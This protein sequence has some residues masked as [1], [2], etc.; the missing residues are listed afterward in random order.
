MSKRICKYQRSI[1][2][3][4]TGKIKTETLSFTEAQINSVGGV[5]ERNGV[6]IVLAQKLCNT[7]SVYGNHKDIKYS[8][9]IVLDEDPDASVC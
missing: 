3:R 4:A 8:Y 7:W 2:C 1:L 6:D 9:N 5:L